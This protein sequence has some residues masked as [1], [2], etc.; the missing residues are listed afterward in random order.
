MITYG[1]EAQ[2]KSE[3]VELI[4][5]EKN[6]P[7]RLGDPRISSKATNKTSRAFWL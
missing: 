2:H 3:N 6:K 5:K 1:T 7:K 4:N